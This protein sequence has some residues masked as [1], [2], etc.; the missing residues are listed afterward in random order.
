[1]GDSKIDPET[2]T[3]E[4]PKPKRCPCSWYGILLLLPFS[5]VAL[6]LGVILQVIWVI[7]LVPSAFIDCLVNRRKPKDL[8]P[9]P[10]GFAVVTGGSSGIGADIARCLA[11][12][13]WNIVLVARSK[14]KMEA[15]I[16]ELK[17]LGSPVGI[18]V[19]T[20]AMD[21]STPTAAADMHA[22]VRAELGEGKRVDILV[23]NAGFA[24]NGFFHTM[25]VERLQMQ[26][27]LNV[28][29]SVMLTR[30]YLNEM[31]AQGRGRILQNASI[32]SYGAGP[33]EA[34][35]HASKAYVRAFSEALAYELADTDITVTTLCPGATETDFFK[36]AAAT[37]SWVKTKCSCFTVQK[38]MPV[39]KFGVDSMFAGKTT[40]IPGIWN[41]YQAFVAPFLPLSVANWY[42][43]NNWAG[44]LH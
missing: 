18:D 14:D 5:L 22:A 44:Q 23:N 13:G 11:S 40:A 24:S 12:R 10:E 37:D 3:A 26:V 17:G 27:N 2:C 31:V 21:M 43:F 1:M 42:I 36:V 19:R 28:G 6:V 32:A 25:P 7:Y 15:L 4:I 35:Y 16:P 9:S 20:V 38:S 41:K 29:T 34:A 33:W 8:K 39:A 30:L